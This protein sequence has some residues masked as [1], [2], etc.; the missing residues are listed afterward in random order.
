MSVEHFPKK[1]ELARLSQSGKYQAEIRMTKKLKER[2]EI[3]ANE[4]QS[5]ASHF[6]GEKVSMREM[7]LV[8]LKTTMKRSDWMSLISIMAK[9]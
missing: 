6:D 5:L 2:N 7:L 9:P 4:W 8:V 1:G 3:E